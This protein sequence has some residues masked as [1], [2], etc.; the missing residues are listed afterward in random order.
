MVGELAFL[1][2]VSGGEENLA[3]CNL[4]FTII[5]PGLALTME[6]HNDSEALNIE[7]TLDVSSWVKNRIP[8]FSRVTGL[9]ANHHEKLCIAYLQRLEREMA[10]IN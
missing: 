6:M 4:L 1:E 9:S 10:V 3:D 2:V 8:G 5:P 7:N